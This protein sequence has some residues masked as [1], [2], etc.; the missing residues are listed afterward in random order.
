[1][2]P[3]RAKVPEVGRP[4]LATIELSDGR[5]VRLERTVLI[6]RQPT[7]RPGDQDVELVQVPDPGRSVSKTHLA[8][9]VD[10]SGVWVRDRDSTNG[11]VV[12]LAD[13]QQ[14]LCAAE[15]QVRLP[16][17]ASVAFGDYALRVS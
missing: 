1:M 3:A 11:T 12:T 16:A 10:R 4:D 6:G 14:I 7:P 9:G 8:I 13:G 2:R 5:T 17:G 15:Q